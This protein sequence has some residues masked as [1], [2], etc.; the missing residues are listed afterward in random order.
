M[1]ANV[2]LDSAWQVQ[3]SSLPEA[4]LSAMASGLDTGALSLSPAHVHNL[5][6]YV[7]YARELPNSPAGISQWMSTEG[8]LA[9][10]GTLASNPE[11][12][13]NAM[14]TFFRLVKGHASCWEVLYGKN[15]QL[16]NALATVAGNIK[17]SGDVILDVCAHTKAL[18]TQREAWDALQ[19]GEA[20]ALSAADR[21][22]VSSLPNYVNSLKEQLKEYSRKV[23]S[24]H[25]EG[26]RFRDEARRQIIPATLRKVNEVGKCIKPATRDFSAATMALVRLQ[27]RI[28][29]LSEKLQNMEQLLREVL[30]ASS[31]VHSAW[32]SLTA[33]IDASN[34]QLQLIT[35]GQQLARF[36]IYFGRF[37]GQWKT[38]EQSATQ[39]GRTLAQY[40]R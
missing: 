38:I 18:G 24:V 35:S 15:L 6:A 26:T 14:V 37:L 40:Q 13:T 12:N 25:L 29:E 31:H 30:T 23:E 22:I 27:M 7:A 10:L 28:R 5:N 19:G 8:G 36:A 17:R 20:L 16:S 33:Y 34:N 2:T 4:L 39:M 1:N 9:N 3:A 21:Q 11:L 32:Q